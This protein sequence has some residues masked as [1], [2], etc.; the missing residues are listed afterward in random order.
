MLRLNTVACRRDGQIL[1]DNVNEFFARPQRIGITGRNGCGKSS[2]FAMILG[3]L[4]PDEGAIELQPGITVAH[5][6]QETPSSNDSALNYVMK[7]DE[8]LQQL[9]EQ[10]NELGLIDGVGD[11]SPTTF[12]DD[13]KRT[14][15]SSDVLANLFEQFEHAGGYT[16]EARAGSLLSGLG[17]TAEQHT[18]AADQFSGGWLMR[19]N[20]ARALM[21]PSDLLLLDEPTNHLDI[22]AVFW[23]QGWLR[24]YEGTLLMISHDREFLDAVV[25]SIVHIEN[26]LAARYTGNYSAFERTRAEQLANQ[27]AMYQRQQKKIQEVQRFIDR[28]KA[29]ASKARQAQSRVKMLERMQRVSQAHVD[30]QFSFSFEQPRKLS[31][32]LVVL[33]EATIGYD[34][35]VV[36]RDVEFR[37]SGG[38]R[39]ALLGRNGAG[40]STLV[41]AIVGELALIDGS[42]VEGNNLSCGYFAQH[43]IDQLDYTGNAIDQLLKVDPQLSEAQARNFLGRFGFSGDMAMQ[44]VNVFS[45]GEKARLVLAL[46]VYQRP[47]VLLL[48]EPTNHL[49]MD[50]RYALSEAMQSF[51]GALVVV[52]H[53]RFLLESVAD[54][55]WLIADGHLSAYPDDLEAYRRWLSKRSNDTAAVMTSQVAADTELCEERSSPAQVDTDRSSAVRKQAKRDAAEQRKRL[56]PLKSQV[57]KAEA[58]C[59]QLQ[60]QIAELQLKLADNELYNDSRKNELAGLLQDQQQLKQKLEEAE[61]AWMAASVQLDAAERAERE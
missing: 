19:L 4:E 27:Q 8:R 21:C 59:D 51:E 40:K 9:R 42:R 23:L 46:L 1:F 52:S 43:Q 7:G 60:S 53:D 45:G 61:S 54:E 41:K 36:L 10:M 20:L 5:V 18:M 2:L 39:I 37:L 30:S 38:D 29:K 22:D 12:D 48:D 56:A 57:S 25:N 44:S 35:H 24:R 13:D 31:N 28:F 15:V 6:A 34:E 11:L 16:A 17:F 32:P 14:D 33:E 49:D 26:R 3:E 58:Q 47:N 55:L 50:M